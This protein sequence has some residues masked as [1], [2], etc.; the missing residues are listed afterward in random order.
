MPRRCANGGRRIRNREAV[1]G[2]M[3]VGGATLAGRK[4]A[5]AILGQRYPSATSI[6]GQLALDTDPGVR[7]GIVALLRKAGVRW[8]GKRV[9][10]PTDTGAGRCRKSLDS[11]ASVS[12]TGR[13]RSRPSSPAI[14]TACR[15]A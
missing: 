9:G 15:S 11:G 10:K 6:A 7:Q 1:G 14:S 13:S 12:S 3:T 2:A 4:A 8:L 5:R